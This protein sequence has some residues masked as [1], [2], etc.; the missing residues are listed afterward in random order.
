MDESA[1]L[2][3]ERKACPGCG[4][5]SGMFTANSMNCLAESHR[6]GPARQRHVPAVYGERIQLAKAAGKR[7]ASCG[8]QCPPARYIEARGVRNALAVD[9]ALGCST[10]SVL[11]LLAIAREAGVP[12]SMRL[13]NTVSERTPNLCRLSPPALTIS[14]TFTPRAE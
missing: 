12:L 7:Y 8:G 1:L 9:M 14:R 3:I 4:S 6:H 11:H 5:C 13:V 10:N 2:E